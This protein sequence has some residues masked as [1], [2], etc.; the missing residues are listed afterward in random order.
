MRDQKGFSLIELLIVLISRF[1][2]DCSAHSQP[3]RRPR[4]RQRRQRGIGFYTR[5]YEVTHVH[6]RIIKKILSRR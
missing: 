4:L 2:T 5:R 1:W 3:F 6:G